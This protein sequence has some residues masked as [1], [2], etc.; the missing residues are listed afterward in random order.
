MLGVG[1]VGLFFYKDLEF[2][3]AGGNKAVWLF[4]INYVILTWIFLASSN[5]KWIRM[6][7]IISGWFMIYL[8]VGNWFYLPTVTM[9]KLTAADNLL[10]IN[11]GLSSIFFAL[12]FSEPKNISS[13]E[14]DSDEDIL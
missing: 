7:G 13:T 8:V 12:F 6:F 5:E 3:F 10:H 9:L 2:P 11:L 1:V 14:E 4:R